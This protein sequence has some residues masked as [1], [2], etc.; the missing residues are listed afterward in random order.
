MAS[1]SPDTTVRVYAVGGDGILFDCLN[2]VVGF[3]NAELAIVPYGLTNNFLQSFGENKEELFRDIRAQMT[4]KAIPTD[5]L[6][7]GN[8]YSLNFCLIGVEAA[9]N[10]K[11]IQMN[12]NLE[13]GGFFSWW[14]YLRFHTSLYLLGGLRAL[15]N[16]KLMRQ[17]YEITIDGEEYSGKYQSIYIANGPCYG[18]NKFPVNTAVPNDGKFDV[19]MGRSVGALRS[20]FNLFPYL[21][22]RYYKVPSVFIWKRGKKVTVR[23]GSSMLIA[24]DDEMFVNP[25]ISVEVIPHAVKIV[26]VNGLEYVRMAEPNDA[27][28]AGSSSKT[29]N[30]VFLPESRAE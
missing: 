22:G 11:A 15:F 29:L 4:S 21:N 3:D 28:R 7:T 8:S 17:R 2:G 13:R 26:A 18:G 30:T 14:F 6:Y 1:V 23:S 10:Q 20:L 9:A 24:L 27:G 19:I 5:I 16:E 12:K 25:S